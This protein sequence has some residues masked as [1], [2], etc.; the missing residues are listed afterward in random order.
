M[1]IKF[2]ETSCEL[3]QILLLQEKN[4]VTNMSLEKKKYNGFLT[5][6]HD[7]D[8]LQKMNDSSAQIIAL[9]NNTVIGFALVMFKSFGEMIPVLKPMFAIFET[10]EY[11]NKKL[12]DYDFYVMGQ[13]CIDENFRGKGIFEKLYLK[14]KDCFSTRFELCLTEVSTSNLRSMKAHKKVGFKT[15]HTYTD[16][17]DTWNIL[18]WDWK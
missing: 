5:V 4:H 1:I 7:F 15:I 16:S 14:H 12:I 17:A 13:I 3:Q 2:A 6:K 8:L 18:L 9:E 10:F 11:Q